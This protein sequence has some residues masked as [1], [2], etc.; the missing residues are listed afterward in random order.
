MVIE[1][2]TITLY[3]LTSG[4]GPS[5]PLFSAETGKPSGL[6]VMFA[7]TY[8]F[9]FSYSTMHEFYETANT[10][11]TDRLQSGPS[12]VRNGW[13]IADHLQLYDLQLAL[14]SGTK[15]SVGIAVAIAFLVL[16]VTTWN[17]L[18]SFL[19]ILSI[20][21]IIVDTIAVLILLDWELNVLESTIIILTIGLSFDFTLHYGIAYKL[22]STAEDRESRVVYALGEVGSPVFMAFATT[23]LAGAAMLPSTTLAY[24]QIG[25]F[26]I[27]ET[28]ISWVYATFFFTSLL[29]L[30]GPSGT[31]CQWNPRHLRCATRQN[32]GSGAASAGGSISTG[33]RISRDIAADAA[34]AAAARRKKSSIVS[35]NAVAFNT[36]SCSP[37]PSSSISKMNALSSLDYSRLDTRRPLTTYRENDHDRIREEDANHRGHQEQAI[38]ETEPMITNHA[39]PPS[40]LSGSPPRLQP[41][42]NGPQSA[43]DDGDNVRTA[44]GENETDQL[45]MESEP[46]PAYDDSSAT[47]RPPKKP[48]LKER[49]A[50]VLGPVL[51]RFSIKRPAENGPT[52]IELDERDDSQLYRNGSDEDQKAETQ[53]LHQ[54]VP[55]I[56]GDTSLQSISAQAKLSLD[57]EQIID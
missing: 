31:S 57:S 29:H 4:L 51:H 34:L 14:A 37:L 3:D 7:S 18:I 16:F 13:L 22:C 33:R 11:I 52:T 46:N 32:S 35:F 6:V 39:A 12:I 23:F 36:V 2:P 8:N 53:R 17:P 27:L 49:A 41:I 19:A 40:D 26:M 21:A 38:V 15:V 20:C 5:G 9:T 42:G 10:W 47:K 30:L 55:F 45:H 54:D 44:P 50:S 43:A 24:F 25:L 1:R 56:D 48:S 28:T